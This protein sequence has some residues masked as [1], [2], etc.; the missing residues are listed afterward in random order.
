LREKGATFNFKNF[1]PLETKSSFTQLITGC[2][3]GKVGFLDI[4]ADILQFKEKDW[5]IKTTISLLSEK[6]FSVEYLVDAFPTKKADFSLVYLSN[7]RLL[8]GIL[9]IIL[10]DGAYIFVVAPIFE[11]Y[12]EKAVN[13]NSFLKEK[14]IIEIN[15]NGEIIWENSLAYQKG[16][17]HLWL[18]LIGRESRGAVSPGEEYNEVRETLIKGITEKLVDSENGQSVVERIYRR[19]ELFS[20]EHLFKMPDLIVVLKNGYGFSNISDE[21]IFDEAGVFRKKIKT[22]GAGSGVILTENVRKGFGCE[23]VTITSIAASVL[24]CMGCSVP[25]WMEGKVEERIFTGNSFSLNPPKYDH[26]EGFSAISEQDE[27]LIKD[28]LK[29]L[30][31]L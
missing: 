27:D 15:S 11:E 17:G 29:G 13:I 2:N 12:V 30:G 31:Y 24:Y 14:D 5:F 6:K 20:G 10:K 9:D 16:Y 22:Y 7:F 1:F 19:E 25:S 23:D 4:P 3:P 21:M 18:S 26:D 28:R 8:D